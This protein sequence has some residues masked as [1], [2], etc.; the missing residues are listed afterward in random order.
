MKRPL[1]PPDEDARL[2]ALS[3]YDL[4]DTPPEQAL[5]DLTLLAS[6]ICEAPIA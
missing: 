3:R 4:L 6:H 5:D 1:Q 2:E